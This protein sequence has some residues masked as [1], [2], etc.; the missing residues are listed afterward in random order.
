[1]CKAW[2]E[3]AAARKMRVECHWRHE[4]VPVSRIQRTFFV[5]WNFIWPKIPFKLIYFGNVNWHRF[6]SF[7]GRKYFPALPVV[8]LWSWSH[9]PQCGHHLHEE[10]R[11][12]ETII[13]LRQPGRESRRNRTENSKWFSGTHESHRGDL[14]QWD[15]LKRS[16]ARWR[17]SD[18]TRTNST[19]RP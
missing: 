7:V 12:G 3:A 14:E 19:L 10:C 17:S 13:H 4:S 18:D 8:C 9:L 6:H 2:R 16:L 1:M 15:R 5:S 11:T